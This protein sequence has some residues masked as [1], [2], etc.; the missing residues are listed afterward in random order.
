MAA[1]EKAY[2]LFL[3]FRLSVTKKNGVGGDNEHQRDDGENRRKRPAAKKRIPSDSRKAS[4]EQQCMKASEAAKISM[5]KYR[6]Q[7]WQERRVLWRR[8]SACI[9]IVA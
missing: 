7:A 1:N 6:K 9:N 4:V 8:S 3:L 2:Y 5:L